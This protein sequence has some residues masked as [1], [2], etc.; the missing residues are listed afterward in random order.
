MFMEER[1]F[2]TVIF[3]N[4]RTVKDQMGPSRLLTFLISILDVLGSNFGKKPDILTEVYIVFF[5]LSR[6][7]EE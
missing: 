7:I 1:F 3:L 4:Q 6:Q 5:S 2:S